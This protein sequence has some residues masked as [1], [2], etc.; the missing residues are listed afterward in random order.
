M[1]FACSNIRV[2]VRREKPVNAATSDRGVHLLI[3]EQN[4]YGETS[5]HLCRRAAA[6]GVVIYNPAT[7]HS[8]R[9]SVMDPITL[10]TATSALT[11]LGT[12]CAKGAASELGKDLWSQAKALLGFNH[13]PEAKE[14]PRAIATRLQSDD[15]LL[16][17][18]ME[19]LANTNAQD[20][21]VQIAG[22]LVGNLHS[23]KTVVAQKIEGNITL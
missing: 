5:I 13:E 19:L 14:L 17:K 9:R 22:S 8:P 11:V 1:P 10:A 18:V 15:A 20:S 4:R 21:S 7:H 12:E 6:I 3:C 2:T 16:S 23:Q